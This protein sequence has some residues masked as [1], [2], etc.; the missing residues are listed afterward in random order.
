[1]KLIL[2]Y[3]LIVVECRH[4]HHHRHH[5]KPYQ[6]IEREVNRGRSLI[7]LDDEEKGEK[8]WIEKHI[9]EIKERSKNNY[10]L[11]KWQPYIAKMIE[12]KKEANNDQSTLMEALHQANPDSIEI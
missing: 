1:M 6:S 8:S 7:S 12:K 10:A 11:W 5:Q 3:S 2:L 9:E 4:H